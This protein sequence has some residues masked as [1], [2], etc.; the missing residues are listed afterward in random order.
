M[1]LRVTGDGRLHGV[2]R[3][4]GDRDAAGIGIGHGPAAACDGLA[5]GRTAVHHCDPPSLVISCYHVARLHAFPAGSRACRPDPLPAGRNRRPGGACMGACRPGGARIAAA[6]GRGVRTLPAGP[7][8]RRRRCGGG[9]SAGTAA[10]ARDRR[11]SRT[12]ARP[13]ILPVEAEPSL[14]R[15]ALP[16]S[17]RARFRAHDDDA[18][19]EVAGGARRGRGRG[20]TV[21]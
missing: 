16:L 1:R 3:R 15:S 18:H 17:A 13:W 4:V 21:P 8:S 12:R 7:R 19:A 10:S 20:A 14:P 11:D 9:H 5:A 2:G 6:R